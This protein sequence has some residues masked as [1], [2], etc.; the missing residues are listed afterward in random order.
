[1]A[2]NFWLFSFKTPMPEKA[3]NWAKT[4]NSVVHWLG[5]DYE[6][7]EDGPQF[8]REITRAARRVHRETGMDF[9]GSEF[10][11]EDGHL[12]VYHDDSGSGCVEVVAQIIRETLHRFSL[13]NVVVIE[14]ADT[15]SRPRTGEFHGGVGVITAKTEQWQNTWDL[16]SEMVQSILGDEYAYVVDEVVKFRSLDI[17]DINCDL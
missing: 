5:K 17:P 2:N 13:P 3:A 14:W 6:D 8:T 12:H 4:L 10:H 9:S 7:D 11:Y 1:M 15:C 16:A